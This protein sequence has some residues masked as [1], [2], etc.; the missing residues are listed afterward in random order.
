MIHQTVPLS[1][2]RRGIRCRSRS[3]ACVKQVPDKI[4]SPWPAAPEVVKTAGK[5]HRLEVK[6]ARNRAQVS[7]A[8]LLYQVKHPERDRIAWEERI[9]K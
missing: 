6:T 1:S 4:P 2:A 3:W 7:R 5:T 8:S 9:E